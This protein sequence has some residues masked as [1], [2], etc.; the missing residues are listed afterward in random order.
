MAV[1]VWIEGGGPVEVEWCPGSTP[2]RI[3]RFQRILSFGGEETKIE[4][5]GIGIHSEEPRSRTLEMRKA[6]MAGWLVSF[7]CKYNLLM[8]TCHFSDLRT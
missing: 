7:R 3:D 2:A 6:K 8:R 4:S 5:S 1:L